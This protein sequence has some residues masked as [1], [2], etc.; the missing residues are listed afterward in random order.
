MEYVVGYASKA[1]SGPELNWHTEEKEAYAILFG[2][3]H[4]L[5]Y[6]YGRH[7]IVQT[8]HKSL[9]WLF[10]ITHPGKLS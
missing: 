4:F 7:F 9:R 6:L 8:D 2:I 1:F 10:I 3:D 5:I